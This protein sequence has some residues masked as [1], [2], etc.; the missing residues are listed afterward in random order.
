MENIKTEFKRDEILLLY[1]C[2]SYAF[3]TT[4]EAS[5]EDYIVVL[6]DFKG[7]THRSYGK[8]E[9]FIFGLDD[10]KAKEEFSNDFDEYFLMFNDEVLAF[11]NSIIYAH[12]S[13]N[14]LIEKYKNEFPLKCK[15]WLSKVISHYK[16]Y[17]GIGDVNKSMYHLIR[18][19]H[20][21]E[22]YRSSGVFSL[23]LSKEISDWILKFKRAEN[24]KI[25]KNDLYDALVFL[26]K[27]LEVL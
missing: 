25:Y 27:Q 17:F 3:G 16:F 18:I 7:T 19:K 24:K 20:I 4:T 22:N 12:E 13:V 15:L 14:E 23:E 26:E 5:D 10:W 2:G 21:I 8:K 1:K 9:Y 6:R 11:P